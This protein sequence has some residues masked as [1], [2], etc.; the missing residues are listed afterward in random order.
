[1]SGGLKCQIIEMVFSDID[2]HLFFFFLLNG[3]YTTV[4]Q[5]VKQKKINTDTLY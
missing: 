4:L 1:M 3:L 5:S 2:K